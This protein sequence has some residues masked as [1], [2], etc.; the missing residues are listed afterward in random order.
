[1][2]DFRTYIQN[3]E[4]QGVQLFWVTLH[5]NTS[6]VKDRL[7]K[8]LFPEIFVAKK[9]IPLPCTQVN[10]GSQKYSGQS[11]VWKIMEAPGE[12]IVK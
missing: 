10:R 3:L 12:I 9:H 4:S 5:R 8:E 11:V 7:K 1:M 2:V 6:N